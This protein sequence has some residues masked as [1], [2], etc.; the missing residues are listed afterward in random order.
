MKLFI[1][2]LFLTVMVEWV[3]F[4]IMQNKIV[5]SNHFLYNIYVPLSILFYLYQMQHYTSRGKYKQ[6]AIGLSVFYVLF[7]VSGFLFYFRIGQ[8]V[9]YNFIVGG[10][11]VT[12]FTFLYFY[13]L[14]EREDRVAVYTLP[15]FWINTGLLLYYLPKTIFYTCFE[16]FTFINESAIFFHKLFFRLNTILIIVLYG[17]IIINFLCTN[18]KTRSS[19]Q[20]V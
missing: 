14:L 1:P 18:R 4:Y 6:L 16:Y 2:Y 10:F 19:L 15:A 7:V 3:G 8:F 17:C 11:I 9:N 5:K 20:S 13:E 12:A